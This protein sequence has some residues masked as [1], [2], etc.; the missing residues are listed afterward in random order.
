ME[1]E[2]LSR[3][4]I[5]AITVFI[6]ISSAQFNGHT[7]NLHAIAAPLHTL[8]SITN[9]TLV[10]EKLLKGHSSS[11]KRFKSVIDVLGQIESHLALSDYCKADTDLLSNYSSGTFVKYAD[12]ASKIPSGIL[13]GKWNWVGD[14]QG[15]HSIESVTNPK[16]GNSFKGKYSSAV[17]LLNNKPIFGT[18]TVIYGV[19]LPDSCSDND[20]KSLLNE[21][22]IIIKTEAAMIYPDIAKE[23]LYVYEVFSE[24]QEK[25]DSGATAVIVIIGLI[26]AIVL[27]STV[28][29]YGFSSSDKAVDKNIHPRYD[30]AFEDS[31]DRTELLSNVSIQ[32]NRFSGLKR[33]LLDICRVFS[34][35]SNGKKLFGTE[36]A[37]GPLA[38]LNGIRVLSMW[39]V[40]LG[41]TYFFSVFTIDNAVELSK[42]VQR[43]TF[44]PIING[45]FSVDSFFFLSGLLVAYL[46]FKQIREKGK[47][48]WPYYFL[49]R[50]WRL[51]PLYAFVI[52]YNTFISPHTIF[53]PNSYIVG[54]PSYKAGVDV[55]KKYWWTNLLYINNMYP[56]Y[57]N[58]QTTC[59]GWSWYLAND[60][61]FFMVLGPIVILTLGLKGKLKY[62]GVALTASLILAGII[63][64]G[65]LVWYYGIYSLI[66]PSTKHLDNPWAKNNPIYDKPFARW[67]VY[68]VGMLTGYVLASTNNRIKLNRIKAA[69]GWCIAI[70]TGLAVIYGMYYYNHNPGTHMTLVQ[71]AFYVA[72]SRTAWGMCLCWVVIACVSGNGGPVNDILSWKI[73]APLGRLTYAAY[74][75][76]PIVMM[77]YNFN[78]LQPLHFSDLTMVYLF[79]ANLVMSYLVAFIVS[80]MV[81]AP[82]IQLEKLLLAPL[83]AFGTKFV[84]GPLSFVCGKVMSKIQRS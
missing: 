69:I 7:T 12:A 39:W 45:T 35:T 24:R 59:L 28:V 46:A 6:S 58:I 50:Y 68:L 67:S 79:I 64:R 36:T 66:G 76:H 33:K 13:Q 2:S 11:E 16:T 1:L 10:F 18:N 4:F 82:M 48:N 65:I 57:G 49:H 43:F 61:Q 8:T 56:N 78:G 21:L 44:Q 54:Q 29:D 77:T 38:C 81:E 32:E 9:E 20:V 62:I 70:G 55:C 42:V 5:L 74:L 80:M 63:V 52:L 47:F 27:I 72:L 75:V 83:G 41:H 22:I 26:G 31:S 40:I 37:I 25:L 60:M 14:Y 73:W 34:I 84:I 3:I 17:L 19:C 71:S 51:T 30:V 23:N 15:C 53:G